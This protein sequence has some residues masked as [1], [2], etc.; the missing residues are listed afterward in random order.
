VSKKAKINADQVDFTDLGAGLAK[1]VADAFQKG[2]TKGAK[3]MSSALSGE[4]DLLKSINDEIDK[5]NKKKQDELKTEKILA[6]ALQDKISAERAALQL[7]IEEEKQA[8]LAAIAQTKMNA[9]VAKRLML[10]AEIMGN[11]KAFYGYQERMSQLE[12]DITG[13]EDRNTALEQQGKLLDDLMDKEEKRD[14][15]EEKREKVLEKMKEV[16]HHLKEQIGYTQELADLLKTPELAKALFAEQMAEKLHEAY[17]GM[18]EFKKEGLSAGQAIQAQFK[19]LSLKSMMGLSDT[20]GALKG[21][22]QEYGSIG[23][24]SKEVV[25]EVGIMA[26]H[27]G[28]SGEEAAKLNASLSKIPGETSESAAHAMEMTGHLAEMQGIAPGK[29]MKDMAGNTAEMARA[30]GKGA[31]AFGK[32]VIN[33]HKMGVEMSTASKIADGLLD[34]ESRINNQM[35][36]S[37]LLGREINLDKAA[38]LALHNDLE[39]ATA[40]VLKNI[41]GAAEFTKMNRLEQD[42]LAKAAGMTVEEMNK[43]LDAA[44]EQNKYFGEQS[45]TLDNIIGQTMEIGGGITKFAKENAVWMLSTVQLL[46]QMNLGKIKQ[47]ALDIAHW[48]KEK[49][50]WAAEKAHWL[51]KRAQAAMG[52]G[53][54]GAA[55]AGGAAAKVAGGA[56]ETAGK[57]GAAAKTAPSPAAGAGVAGFLTGLATGLK[58]FDGK[59]LKGAAFMAGAAVLFGAGIA[60][61][62]YGLSFIPLPDLLVAAVALPVFAGGFFLL[63]KVMGKINV[64]AVAQGSLALILLG[65]ALIPAAFA[66]SLLKGV[67]VGSIIAFSIALPLLALAAA[68]LGFLFPFIAAGAA[69][70]ALLGIGMIAVGA[71]L[72]VLQSAQGGLEVFGKLTELASGAMGLGSVAMALMGIGAGLG[73]IAIAGFTAMP[74]LGMLI[75]LAAAAPALTG[76]ASALMGGGGEGEKSDKMDELIA[77]VKSL[78]AEMANI[79]VNLDGKKVGEALRGSMNT[80]RIR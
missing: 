17:E 41:G 78:K 36:A 22:A 56:A 49:A 40:E 64:G 28:I 20:K 61:L 21:F 2:A 19:G 62:A 5:I 48:A 57:L 63:S 68:G 14:A 13:L 31:E 23:G 79:T 3:A 33:L 8:N 32:S 44:E 25:N 66:F 30:G 72:L 73:S 47:Y 15:L 38:E 59:A 74:I 71:G 11:M 35:E 67:D 58:A 75:G 4:G 18:E 1:V 46:G 12:A 70:L 16:K 77:E 80:S 6:K 65:A 55:A 43:A 54:G 29:I 42:A 50:Q 10:N 76:L 45:S 53:G 27:F 39:G 51:W 34:F 37:V 69:S 9:A 26:H 24:I 7:A 52:L 60:A